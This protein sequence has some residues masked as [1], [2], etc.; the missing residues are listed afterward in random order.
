MATQQKLRT[1][2]I[3]IVYLFICLSNLKFLQVRKSNFV[4]SNTHFAITQSLLPRLGE[5]LAPPLQ[6]Y[7]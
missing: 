3:F 1:L 6:Q 4:I 7:A 2:K 5:M